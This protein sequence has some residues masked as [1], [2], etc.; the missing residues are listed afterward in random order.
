MNPSPRQWTAGFVLAVF[1]ATLVL[2]QDKKGAAAPPRPALTVTTALPQAGDVALRLEANGNVAAWQEA[3]VGA[4]AAGLRLTDVRVNVG[5]VVRQGD[6]LATF[7][8]DSIDAEVKQQAAAVAEAEAALAEARANRARGEKLVAPG[9]ISQQEIDKLRSATLA[10]EARLA[11]AR[12][13]IDAAR[14]RLR[15]TRVLAPDDGVIS[16][17]GATVGAVVQPGQ[18]LFRLIRDGRLEWRAEVTAADLAR[19]K[20]G[21]AVKLNLPGGG[22]AAGK[23]R[24]LAPTIDPQTR[25]ALVYVDLTTKGDARAGMFARGEIELGRSSATTVPQQAVVIRDGFSYVFTLNPDHRVSQ[26]RVKTGRRTGERVEILEG[27]PTGVPV[28]AAGAGFLNDG[29]VVAVAK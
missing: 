20:P 16:S 14:V 19:V 7:N 24:M 1:A 15:Q 29:D 23:V 5:D 17:R 25:N 26:R 27:L 3:I 13:A 9:A 12:A 22:T 18:E 28:V 4:E 10:T 8:A 2:A 11:A 21:Q 6:T